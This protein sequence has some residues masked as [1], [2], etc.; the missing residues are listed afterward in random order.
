MYIKEHLDHFVY[1]T[2]IELLPKQYFDTARHPAFVR[3]EEGVNL[4]FGFPSFLATNPCNLSCY[5][6]TSV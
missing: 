5:I 6:K 3:Y 2:H 4:T 1:P